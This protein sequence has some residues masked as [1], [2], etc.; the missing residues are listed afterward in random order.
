MRGLGSAA[1]K[2]AVPRGPSLPGRYAGDA[3]I[4]GKH[5]HLRPRL[6]RH[7]KGERLPERHGKRAR[8]DGRRERHRADRRPGERNR[9]G[10]SHF[11]RR[12]AQADRRHVVDRRGRDEV[13]A[14]RCPNL[15]NSF[16]AAIS[17]KPNVGD[18][19]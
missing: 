9:H 15:P 17:G 5:R 7:V 1:G 6:I 18:F 13:W 3:D 16:P 14:H 8:P 19:F 2:A 10:P 11:A 12:H 4:V